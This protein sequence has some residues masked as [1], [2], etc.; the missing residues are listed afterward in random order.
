[1]VTRTYR[2]DRM[3]TVFEAFFTPLP[4]GRKK[5][6]YAQNPGRL[7]DSRREEIL[8]ALETQSPEEVAIRYRLRPTY[9]RDRVEVWAKEALSPQDDRVESAGRNSLPPVPVEPVP[10]E[11]IEGREYRMRGHA[12]PLLFIGTAP[13]KTYGGRHYLFREKS[14]GKTCYSLVALIEAFQ[15]EEERK[16]WNPRRRK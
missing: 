7:M 9:L 14:G 11:L 10:P 1:M 2:S 15:G 8:E 6:E 12:A 4:P 5:R 13:G 3:V 16:R